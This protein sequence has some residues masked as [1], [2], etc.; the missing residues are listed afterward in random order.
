MARK[1]APFAW[2]DPFLLDDQLTGQ[3]RL[4][5]DTVLADFRISAHDAFVSRAIALSGK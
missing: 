2:N 1:P 4:I 5:R 3:E